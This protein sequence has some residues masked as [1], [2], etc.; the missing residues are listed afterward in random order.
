M[1]IARLGLGVFEGPAG[2]A[3]GITIKPWFP[4]HEQGMATGF[5]MASNQIAF[6]L[7]PPICVAI[8][9]HLG[10][11]AV[12][13]CFAVPG[14]VFGIIWAIVVRNR[15]DLCAPCNEEERKYIAG[16]GPDPRSG[17][18]RQ[19][20]SMGR[21]DTV[22]RARR[23]TIALQTRA[24][25]FKSW[26]VWANC[27]VFFFFGPCF[28]GILTWIPSYLVTAK[29]YSFMKMRLLAALPFLGGLIGA[30]S[31]GWLS[32]K[33]W[34]GRRKPIMILGSIASVIMMCFLANAPANPTALGVILFLSG[35]AV[36]APLS[37]YISYSMGLTT[38]ETYPGGA[39]DGC[40]LGDLGGLASPLIVGYMLDVFKSFTPVFYY[41]GLAMF[42]SLIS[43]FTMIEP[44]QT[45][46]SK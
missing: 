16:S 46:E 17:I 15:P 31:G 28:W 11:R 44:L 36:N 40:D 35:I 30:T 19:A 29:G 39:G 32:N 9:T 12:F 24:E 41:F 43:V 4:R 1:K 38:H 42:V 27:L 45:V 13:Y 7:V 8:A 5:Y 20:A 3:A 22:L 10:W 23:R 18:D 25:V 14:A 6:M 2:V 37:Q 33:A 26:N 21:I 34:K